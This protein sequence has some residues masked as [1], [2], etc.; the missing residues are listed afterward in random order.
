MKN[1]ASKYWRIP[2]DA[3]RVK[4]PKGKIHILKERCKGCGFCIEYCP[5]DVLEFSDEFNEKAYHPPRVKDEKL[6]LCCHLCE[7]VCPEYAIWSTE[8]KDEELHHP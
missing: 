2:L 8:E 3:D 4:T 1:A 5:R 7:L 6:C